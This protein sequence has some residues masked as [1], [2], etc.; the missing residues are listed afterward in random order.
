MEEEEERKHNGRMLS[1]R[2]GHYKLQGQHMQT[3]PHPQVLSNWP[4]N[5]LKHMLFK[6]GTDYIKLCFVKKHHEELKLPGVLPLS[7]KQPS[8]NHQTTPRQ[9]PDDHQMTPSPYNP[10][11]HIATKSTSS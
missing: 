4:G 11:L 9:P 7:Y 1:Q 6:S 10:P 2:E 3:L 8:D 5:E